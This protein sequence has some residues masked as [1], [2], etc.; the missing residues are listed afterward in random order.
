MPHI[1]SLLQPR[2]ARSLQWDSTSIMV[3]NHDFKHLEQAPVVVAMRTAEQYAGHQG[4]SFRTPSRHPRNPKNQATDFERKALEA[5]EKDAS[6]ADVSERVTVDG[7]EVMRYAQ[8]VRIVQDCLQC[9]G[10][11]VGA[12][13]PFG[14]PKEGM[15]A[16]ELRAAFVLDRSPPTRTKPR[17]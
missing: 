15:K 14:Y 2:R 11:P 5:F 4:M 9:H 17:P 8:P 12:K 13:D 3:P 7:R 10:D 6:L 1:I 16:G